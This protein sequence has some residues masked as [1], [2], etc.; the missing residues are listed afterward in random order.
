MKQ[1]IRFCSAILLGA[2]LLSGISGLAHAQRSGGDTTAPAGTLFSFDA[3]AYNGSTPACNGS[4]TITA[5]IPGYYVFTTMQVSI[6]GKPINLPDKSVL[7]VNLYS[8]IAA[9]GEAL[10][11]VRLADMLILSKIGIAKSSFAF[12][13]LA[14]TLGGSTRVMDKVVVTDANGNVVMIGR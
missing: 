9:T 11:P 5:P 12:F 6:K 1:T 4:Y 7:T 10:P 13:D 14:A 8:K 3:I 2:T